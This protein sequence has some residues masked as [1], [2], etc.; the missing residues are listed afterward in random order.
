MNSKKAKALRKQLR[1]EG[2]SPSQQG[3]GASGRKTYLMCKK[4][5]EAK[6]YDLPPLRTMHLRDRE[7]RELDGVSDFRRP[8]LRL[9][10][11]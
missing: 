8:R 1:S 2:I 9:V 11:A 3:P 5:V 10:A 6:V 7:D 4:T